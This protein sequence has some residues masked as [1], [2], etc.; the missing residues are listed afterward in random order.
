M[1]LWCCARI[2][3]LPG[4]T[5]Q[6]SGSLFFISLDMHTGP[7]PQLT[8]IELIEA[9][10]AKIAAMRAPGGAPTRLG[11]REMEA[12]WKALWALRANGG[13]SRKRTHP[14]SNIEEL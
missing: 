1:A 7:A 4:L 8:V 12:R 11:T 10:E 3:A 5:A 14:F 13:P 9:L 2:D 6:S